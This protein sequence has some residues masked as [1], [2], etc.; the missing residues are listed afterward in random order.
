MAAD[1]EHRP[2]TVNGKTAVVVGGTSGIGEA[3]AL[4]FATEGADVVATSR[5]ADKTAA[6]TEA[7]RELGAKTIEQTCDVTDRGSITAL[8]DAVLDEFGH[9]DVLVNSQG[10]ISRQAVLDIDEESWDHVHDILLDGVYRSVQTFA[11]KMDTGSIINI[12]SLASHLAIPNAPAYTSA[13]AGVNGFTRAASKE[14][15][16]DIRVNAIEPGFVIT[17]LNEN[18]YREGTEK[19]A[20]IDERAPMDRVAER[21]ELVGAA[22]YLASDAASYTTGEVIAVDGGFSDSVF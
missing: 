12:S 18:Q 6:T 15:A 9:V 19:R 14:L 1:Y 2:V 13:K 8:R 17:A 22:V 7:I 16:P 5:S 10:V 20:M 11:R 4:G 21:E 3:I